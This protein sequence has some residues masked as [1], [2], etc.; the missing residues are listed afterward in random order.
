MVMVCGTDTPWDMDI[1]MAAVIT[2][3]IHI[4]VMGIPTKTTDTI[5][6]NN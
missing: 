2:V 5:P 4:I 3:N 1:H 6:S